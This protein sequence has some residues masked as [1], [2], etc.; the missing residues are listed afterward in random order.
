M[1]IYHLRCETRK[2]EQ[3]SAAVAQSVERRLGKAEVTSSNLVSSSFFIHFYSVILKKAPN[4]GL[5]CL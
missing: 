1:I 2:C 4:Q 3:A 5:F